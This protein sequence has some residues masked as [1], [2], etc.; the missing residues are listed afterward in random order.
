MLNAFVGGETLFAMIAEAA[1]TNGPP[2]LAGARIDY[3]IVI[4]R[5]IRAIHVASGTRLKT[6]PEAGTPRSQEKRGTNHDASRPED[7]KN[8]NPE[9]NIQQQMPR[10]TWDARQ[11]KGSYAAAAR[12]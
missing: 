2:I 12:G 1:A 7:S 3:A 6:A 5:T 8:R 4:C 11:L 9:A 10:S